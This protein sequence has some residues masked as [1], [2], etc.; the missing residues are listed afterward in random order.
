M[1]ARVR[2]TR[3]VA[4]ALLALVFAAFLGACGDDDDDDDGGSTPETTAA[5]GSATAATS[6][7][8]SAASG[9]KFKVGIF[10]VA[11]A[12]LLDEV[13]EGM[14]A[15][16]AAK[17]FGPDRVSFDTQNAQGDATLIQTIA[18]GYRD[19]DIDMIVV[20]GTPA[21]LATFQNV[22][23]KPIIAVAMGDPVG[24]GVADSLEKPGKNVTGSIDW[25]EPSLLLDDMVKLTPP[26]KT[27]G[28]LYDPSNQNMQVWVA[29]L[30][31]ALKKYP[32]VKFEEATIASSAD[33]AAAARSLGGRVDAMLI[34]PDAAVSSALPAVAQVADSNKIALYLS[35]GD[36]SVPGVFATIGPD[37]PT[38]GKYA[39]EVAARV[40]AG[41]APGDVPFLG[42]ESVEWVVSQS[43]LDKLELT[44]PEDILATAQVVE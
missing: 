12:A 15:E 28:T 16:M 40:L 17:G 37:Y 18:R 32:D 41:E 19:T 30:K 27:L 29:A 44:I 36:I 20:I 25:V 21:V 24:A 14:K 23:D 33:V 13:M 4:V 3:Y 26:F 39:G 31:E 35:G 42:P 11:E 34:G 2:W 6:P 22:T 7:S 10:Q 8:A 5:T 1:I 43:M 38:L 9:E